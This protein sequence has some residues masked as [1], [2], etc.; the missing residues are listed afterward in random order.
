MNDYILAVGAFTSYSTAPSAASTRIIALTPSGPYDDTYWFS[1]NGFNSTATQIKPSTNGEYW[2]VGNFTTY[3]NTGTYLS[4]YYERIQNNGDGYAE[5]NGFPSAGSVT[6]VT[7][8]S[9]SKPIFS[10]SFTAFTQTDS[11]LYSSSRI[12][13]LTSGATVDTTFKVGTGFNS[14]VN[15]TQLQTDGKVLVGGIFTTFNGISVPKLVRLTTTG[16]LDKEFT[17]FSAATNV[18]RIVLKP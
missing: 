18:T 17:F 13:R 9:D 7:V 5:T 12:I 10:G 4:K 11:S 16:S 15:I 8:Q 14:T 2:A 3:S 6:N 1:P